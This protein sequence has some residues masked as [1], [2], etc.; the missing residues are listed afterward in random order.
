MKKTKRTAVLVII[1]FLL[2]LGVA[3]YTAIFGVA[4]R[5]KVEYIK[6]GLDL[7]GG[8]SVTYEIQEDDYSDKDL[9]DTK[10]K[11]EQRVE[12]YTNE[13]SVYEDG[14]KKI[15]AEIP[16]VT[17]ADEILNALNIEGKLEFL[18]PDNYTKWSQGQEYEAA[19]TGDDI[20]NAT[21][22]IDSD[23][24][25]DNVVQL[26]F[27]DEGAQKFADVTAAN[28][29][30]IVYIIYDNK[31]VSAPTV[32]SA[33]TGGSA[34]INKIGSY[35]EAEQL[36][37]TIRIGALPLTLKQVRS[38]IVGATLGSDAISTS[39]KAGAIGIALVFLIMIIVFRIPGLVASFALAF[40]TIL[41]LLVLNLFNVTLTLPG[42]AGV[43][44]SV[45][46][47]VDA[48]VIIFTRIKEELADGKS[49]KQAVKGGF[50]NALSAIID[51]NVTTLI[52][53]LV[54]GIFGTG[55]IKGFAITLAIGV[56]LSVFTA[57]A[58]SQSLLTAL[59]NLGVTDA[60]YFGVAR[61]PKKTNFVKAGKF[62]MLGS[63]IVI[64]A[65]FCM[66]PVNNK[67]KGSPL[68]FSVE[69]AGGT[70]LTV[71]FDK[72]YSLSEA[73]KDIVPVIAEAAGIGEAGI[74]VQTVSGT[75]EIVFKMPELSD[76]GTDDSQ[77]SKVR[78]A[79]TDKLGA[80]VKEANVI[81]GSVSSEMSKNAIF[82]VILAAIL[83][84]IYIAIRFH[85]VKFGASAVIALLHDVA[86]VFCLYIILR[87]TVGNT[88]IACLLTI[89]GYS[90]NAT[91]I[92]FDRVRENI[93]V[94]KPKKATYKDIVNLSI[95]QTFSRTIYTSLTTFVTI[96]V[97]YIMGV[98][99]IKEFALT[100]MAGVVIGA[101]SSV[102]ITGPLWYY[103]KTKLGK[104][105]KTNRIISYDI[106]KYNKN[107][108]MPP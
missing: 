26:A 12:A 92:I 47:A 91:I 73:E 62:C 85:D 20:K 106:V 56:V 108:Q 52:A 31:V 65:C 81:S 82:S 53:A 96:F 79:L 84:L 61:E 36:A 70:S 67:S 68:N 22:G 48:N 94:M 34:E 33:I 49:V 59:V 83:M 87:L 69:F 2:I 78:S 25:N 104:T 16:G 21:A 18:D 45:G 23:N 74:S 89:V 86:M 77:M 71:G 6:L 32:Q 76:D 28:V 97:L 93:G 99:S 15:T 103:M 100:L 1:A 50:H 64:I 58:V 60:K 27:T 39:L 43:I 37:T 4:D 35:E 102:C 46:M 105:E 95:N 107:R 9:E 29:G 14:D 57:L 10:Y 3:I 51:G 11:I 40:Y 24:G 66:M 42:I 8:L 13:Y 5:G 88:C 7:K 55:T 19:L 63:L 75:N 38:N 101:Y 54:L 80:D 30:N 98:A 41:D 90:I 72:E 17:N 44:L